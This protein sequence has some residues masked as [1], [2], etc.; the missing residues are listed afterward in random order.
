MFHSTFSVGDNWILM[1]EERG[2]QFPL[3]LSVESL[4]TNIN[5]TNRLRAFT[6]N[7]VDDWA[8]VVP[9]RRV[10]P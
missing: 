5:N 4:V 3:P 6:N 7:P 10:T 8:F 9:Q 1:A 2:I